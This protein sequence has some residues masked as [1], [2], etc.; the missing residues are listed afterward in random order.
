MPGQEK[1]SHNRK[2]DARNWEVA[3]S[4]RL[5]WRLESSGY[6]DGL[7][8]SS[9]I[10]YSDSSNEEIWP[11]EVLVDNRSSLEVPAGNVNSAALALALSELLADAPDDVL[12]ERIS[13]Q[14][15]AHQAGPG[16]FD[17]PNMPAQA[18]LEELLR[19][20]LV[21][22]GQTAS[23][24]LADYAGPDN[25]NYVLSQEGLRVTRISFGQPLGWG[26]TTAQES[27]RVMQRLFDRT[28][29][30]HPAM[31]A[32]IRE[33]LMSRPADTFASAICD[34]PVP[35]G[36]VVATLSDTSKLSYDDGR[37][38]GQYRLTAGLAA[39]T[40]GSAAFGLA[41]RVDH[42]AAD[43][44]AGEIMREAGILLGNQLK[45]PAV[46][47]PYENTRRHMARALLRSAR[48]HNKLV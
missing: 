10:L 15:T 27:A 2:S 35:E 6:F 37:R 18:T 33:A 5:K 31:L 36:S 8:T 40:V 21:D 38:I 19:D 41:M 39:S 47:M 46:E 11:H 9:F 45:L 22:S 26:T 28:T 7:K 48:S 24:Q 4:E 3:Y 1:G 29:P 13:L 14:R 34:G 20:M 32:F 17:A 42:Q 25:I 44:I 23:R 12:G 16:R 43:A 30:G